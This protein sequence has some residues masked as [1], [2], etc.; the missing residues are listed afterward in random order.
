M[1][2]IKLVTTLLFLSISTFLFQA[3][4]TVSTGENVNGSING[5]EKTDAPY[6]NEEPEKYQT[7]IWQ[8]SAK[9]TEKF[10]MTRSGD[11]WRMDTLFGAPEQVTTIHTDK[12]YVISSATK[13]YAEYPIG[14]GYND[15][16]DIVNAM[17]GGMLN[18]KAKAAYERVGTDGG[19]TKYKVISDVDKGKESIVYFDDKIGLPVKKEV[20]KSGETGQTPEMTIT[21]SGFKTETDEKLFALPQGLKKISADDMKKLLTGGK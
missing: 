1:N 4:R 6:A 14:H 15:R 16:E 21:L 20:F 19:M 5:V 13:S 17:T 3:C 2:M 12:Q 18:A 9:G 11:K 7:E 10:F 8:T